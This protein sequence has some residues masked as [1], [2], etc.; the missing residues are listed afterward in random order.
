LQLL[1]P[2]R[3]ESWCGCGEVL[4]LMG[5]LVGGGVPGC[6]A[7][8]AWYGRPGVVPG[9]SSAR[10][11]Y[12]SATERRITGGGGVGFGGGEGWCVLGAGRM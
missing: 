4:V 7:V 5:V 10:S 8:L 1:T 3:R 9:L 6:G 11:G 12:V 2:V